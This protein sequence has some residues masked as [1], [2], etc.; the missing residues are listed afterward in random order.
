MLSCNFKHFFFKMEEI[1]II[2][3]DSVQQ[4]KK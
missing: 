2:L 1:K 4:E 3:E